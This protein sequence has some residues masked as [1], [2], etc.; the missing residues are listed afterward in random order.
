[1]VGKARE[2]P[3]RGIMRDEGR[4]LTWLARKTGYSQVYVQMTLLGHWNPSP[5]FRQRCVA[6]LQRPED[7]LFYPTTGPV[8]PRQEVA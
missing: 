4:M 2:H 8:R 5:A 1:M 7:E 3:I 6:V